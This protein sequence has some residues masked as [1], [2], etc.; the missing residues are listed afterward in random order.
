MKVLASCISR[1]LLSRFSICVRVRV[2]YVRFVSSWNGEK[3][4][5]VAELKELPKFPPQSDDGWCLQY[6]VFRI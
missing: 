6:L 2:R 3:T 1:F 4:Y 5:N